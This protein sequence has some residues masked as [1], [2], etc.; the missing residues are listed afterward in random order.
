[1]TSPAQNPAPR[2]AWYAR[3][4]FAYVC[5][6]AVGLLIY[7]FLLLV[8]VARRT[9]GELRGIASVGANVIMAIQAALRGP[10]RI[11][12]PLGPAAVL[13]DEKT[14]PAVTQKETLS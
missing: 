8:F 5:S 12:P 6:F 13:D 7:P 1:M 11:A 2:A 9:L 4:A 3:L 14:E 10:R